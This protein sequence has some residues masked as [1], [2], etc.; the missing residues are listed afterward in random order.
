MLSDTEEQALVD[1]CKTFINSGEDV[2]LAHLL[3]TTKGGPGYRS[4]AR[5]DIAEYIKLDDGKLNALVLNVD[6]AGPGA[7]L[8]AQ[9][10]TVDEESTGTPGDWSIESFLAGAAL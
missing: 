7:L 9:P 1:L 3:M 4:S 6:T 2:T 10:M 5:F 8:S